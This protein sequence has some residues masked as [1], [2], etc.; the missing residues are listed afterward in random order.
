MSERWRRRR[1]WLRDLLHAGGRQ[2]SAVAGR[3]PRLARRTGVQVVLVP[4]VWEPWRYLAPLARHLEA[5]GHG[6][7]VVPTLGYHRGTIEASAALVRA[8]IAAADGTVVIVAH[9][10]GGLVG[11]LVLLD[12]LAEPPTDRVEVAGLVAISTP[13]RGSR[14]AR[15]VPWRSLLEL[16]DDAPIVARL[17]ARTSV[18]DRIVAIQ[19]AWDPHVREP[20]PPAAAHVVPLAVEGH[21]G[22]LDAPETI[23]AVLA[24]V[25]RLTGP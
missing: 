15:W 6:V 7:L 1:V 16:R 25:R 24:A 14:L 22:V 9:S 19:P 8:R 12:W 23:S 3:R 10:K 4:G 11:K 21:F 17:A 18:D 2:V 13:W 20:E 5:A